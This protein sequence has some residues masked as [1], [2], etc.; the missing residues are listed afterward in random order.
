MRG[1]NIDEILTIFE[2]G[3]N[4]SPMIVNVDEGEGGDKVK[5]FIG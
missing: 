1:V 3:V 5:V 2:A 4:S